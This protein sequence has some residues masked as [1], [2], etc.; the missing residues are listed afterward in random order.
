MLKKFLAV[1]VVIWPIAVEAQVFSAAVDRTQL[2]L[3]EALSLTLT[4]DGDSGGSVQPDLSG[5]SPDFNIYSTS[6]SLQSSFVNG[7][8]SVTRRWTVGLMPTRAGRLVIP[9][10]SAGSQQTQPINIDVF[11]NN[12]AAT[13]NA[14]SA[15]VPQGTARVGQNQQ[16]SAQNKAYVTADLKVDNVKPYVQQEINATLTIYD[17]RGIELSADP[18][19]V[20]PTD[21]WVVKMLKRPTVDRAANGGRIIRLYYALFPQKSGALEIPPIQIDG[22][23]IDYDEERKQPTSL[24]GFMKFFEMDF[25]GL[26]GVQ[27]PISVQTKPVKVDVQPIAEGYGS[28]WW[29]P[30]GA[31]GTAVRWADERPQF[32]VGETFA[33]EITVLAEGVADTQMPELELPESPQIKQY[34]EKPVIT[35]RVSDDKVT[36]QLMM[37]V[38]YIPQEAGKIEIPEV[39]IPWFNVDNKSIETAVI[40]AD[41]ILVQP[42]PLMEKEN[43]PTVR[44]ADEPAVQTSKPEY[45]AAVNREI[46]NLESKIKL[47]LAVA[48]AFLAGLILSWM[49]MRRKTAKTVEIGINDLKTV[50]NC[51]KNKDYKALRDSLVAYGQE[52]FAAENI[53]NL[54]DLARCVGRKEFAEQMTKRNADLYANQKE[55]LDAEVIVNCL[56]K[57]REARKNGAK[58]PLPDLYK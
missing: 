19:F 11:P 54:D 41:T 16:G 13:Q 49:L 46:E 44:A 56:K 47:I 35:S 40:P 42:N 33:R 32:K 2:N 28:A 5:L 23:Y 24:G 22:Y 14:S 15:N 53:C 12:G 39:K 57:G 51:L 38:V 7:R 52:Q 10:I 21:E 34:P 9:A 45:D 17:E 43:A 30:S 58:K 1:A 25:G 36:S 55:E 3:G 48:A 26:F 18:V 31:V 27:R 4:L 8:S 37:R 6:N 50:E 20:T 29:L